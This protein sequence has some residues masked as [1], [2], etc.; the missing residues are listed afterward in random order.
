MW[1]SSAGGHLVA[2]LGTS[3][4]VAALEGKLGGFIK[5]DSRVTC[6]VDYFGPSELLTM[7]D[8]PSIIKHNAPD[9]PESLLIGGALQE[10]KDRARSASPI[11]HVTAD[12]APFLIVHGDQ[13]RLVPYNQSE[14]LHARLR[15][16]GVE[17]ELLKMAGEGHGGFRKNNPEPKVGAFLRRHLLEPAAKEE[18]KDR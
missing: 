4:G 16:A 6:M 17:S 11:T 10:H 2:M 18:K 14:V 9:S 8:F 13:D 7:G 5:E 12:D 1:G 15:K 3:G